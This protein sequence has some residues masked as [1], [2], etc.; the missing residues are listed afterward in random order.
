M[1]EHTF[2]SA[3]VRFIG[4]DIHKSY[5]VATGVNANLEE[6]F[7]PYRVTNSKMES[8]AKKHLT[9][10]DAIVI[11][12]TTNTYQVHDLLVDLVHSVT[13]VHPPHV[14]LIARAQV[15]TDK[16]DS[17][18]LARLH[19][20]GLLPAVWIPPQEVRDRRTLI[21][22]RWKMVRLRTT[23]KNRL[24]SIGGAP[25]KLYQFDLG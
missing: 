9:Q 21:A 8:W 19:A 17:L 1:S 12:M 5:F 7:G 20:A 24:H 14:A 6:I 2:P 11:E 15:K 13:V 23:A 16:R 3:P 22:E 18:V 25:Q 10:F 4:F